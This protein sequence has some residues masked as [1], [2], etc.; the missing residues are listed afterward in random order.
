[1]NTREIGNQSETKAIEFLEKNG[2]L[3]I[4]RN[5]YTKFGEIDIIAK[6][7]N[8]LH[9]IEVKSGKNFQ[10]IYNITPTKMKR[11]IKSINVYLKKYKLQNPY[12]IDAITIDNGKLE[13]IKNISFF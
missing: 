9:F 4:D 10:S 7:D 5:F 12:Q 1:M 8:I 2:Y 13:F 11:I 3:I 6:K